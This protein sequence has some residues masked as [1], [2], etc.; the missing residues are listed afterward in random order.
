MIDGKAGPGQLVFVA[1]HNPDT[2]HDRDMR[3]DIY[4]GCYP[5]EYYVQYDVKHEIQ[6]MVVGENI[7]CNGSNTYIFDDEC[8]YKKLDRIRQT[9]FFE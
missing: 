2:F 3:K 7:N 6:R 4:I 9:L 8:V 5:S 1:L